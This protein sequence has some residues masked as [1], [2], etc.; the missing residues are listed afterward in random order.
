MDKYTQPEPI[1]R[2]SKPR[3][4]C[5]YPATVRGH[6]QRGM[7]YEARAVLSNISATGMYLRTKRQITSGENIFVV[8]RLSTLSFDKAQAPHIAASGTVVRV[9]P[10]SDGTLG[11][12][13]K[14]NQ[15]RF[16]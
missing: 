9:E 16:L 1:E 3:V 5:S 14:L 11:V 6:I 12:A 13:L 7:K 4:K 2:R 10:K 8:V 15:H